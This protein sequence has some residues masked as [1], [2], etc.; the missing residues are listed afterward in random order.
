MKLRSKTRR[1]NLKT[2]TKKS[3]KNTKSF[4]IHEHSGISDGHP[5]FQFGQE[6]NRRVSRR[7]RRRRKSIVTEESMT[8]AEIPRKTSRKKRRASTSLAGAISLPISTRDSSWTYYVISRK[9]KY[10]L[11]RLFIGKESVN[12]SEID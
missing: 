4:L 1:K 12:G 11:E 8:K 3:S 7:S 10:T 9:L 6:M 2:T 5:D